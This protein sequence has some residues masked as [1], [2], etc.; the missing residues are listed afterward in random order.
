[1]AFH[2][3]PLVFHAP[4]LK[5]QHLALPNWPQNLDYVA[6]DVTEPGPPPHP[7]SL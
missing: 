1:M 2:T 3:R 4:I 6:Q 7:S 5:P